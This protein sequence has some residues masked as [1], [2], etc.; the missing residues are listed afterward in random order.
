MKIFKESGKPRLPVAWNI[1]HNWSKTRGETDNTVPH[2]TCYHCNSMKGKTRPG[3]FRGTKIIHPDFNYDM[4]DGRYDDLVSAYV[5]L[6]KK[7]NKAERKLK[8]LEE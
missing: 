7:K 6:M 5:E 1:N 3:E 4:Y 8:K 2:P